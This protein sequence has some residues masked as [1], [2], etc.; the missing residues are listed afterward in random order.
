MFNR[1]SFQ[2]RHQNGASA[3]STHVAASAGVNG[4]P[5][6]L[7]PNYV[8]NGYAGTT[9]DGSGDGLPTG[10]IEPLPV[11]LGDGRRDVINPLMPMWKASR[12]D[13][14]SHVEIRQ[15]APAHGDD[16]GA[17]TIELSDE[18]VMGVNVDAPD[19]SSNGGVL[20]KSPKS[21]TWKLVA[22]VVVFLMWI[23]TAS[24]LLFIYMDRYLFP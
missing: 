14:A 1:S 2:P 24:T 9:N 6:S 13:S 10:A 22:L 5:S 7:I 8:G 4:V 20:R 23:S 3:G 17:R 19:T 12:V 18:L 16:L 11:W 15:P 21:E